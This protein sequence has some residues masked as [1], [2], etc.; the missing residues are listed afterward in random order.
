M[1]APASADPR[2]QV[3][4]G[5]DGE[6]VFAG[7]I[8]LSTAP[9][10]H[11][12]LTAVDAAPLIEIDLRRVTYLDSAAVTVLFAHAH[13]PMHI[14]AGADTAVADVLRTCALSQVARVQLMPVPEDMR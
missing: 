1:T 5:R 10:M 9:L 4:V 8:D 3:S 7:E 13:R 2:L 6:V 14:L 12:A 11:A